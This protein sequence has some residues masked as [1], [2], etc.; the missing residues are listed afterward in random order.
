MARPKKTANAA[1]TKRRLNIVIPD[2]DENALEWLNCQ[3]NMSVSIRFAIKKMIEQYGVND[4][5]CLPMSE[6]NTPAPKA[7]SEPTAQRLS[8]KY[9]QTSKVETTSK[10]EPSDDELYILLRDLRNK[11]KRVD[12]DMGAKYVIAL[13]DNNCV[14]ALN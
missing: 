11:I 9:K 1:K 2:E 3:Y 10:N 12:T 7:G 5:T 8:S 13:C 6:Q 4:I 14:I